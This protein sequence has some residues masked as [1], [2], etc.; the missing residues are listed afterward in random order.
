MDYLKQTPMPRE[1]TELRDFQ[2]NFYSRGSHILP[3]MVKVEPEERYASVDEVLSELG[4]IPCGTG[5]GASGS[6]I[7]ERINSYNSFLP[8]KPSSFPWSLL[9][10]VPLLG[11]GAVSFEYFCQYPKHSILAAN[12][13][14]NWSKLSICGSKFIDFPLDNLRFPGNETALLLGG[15][16]GG[17]C[18]LATE[19]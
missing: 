19:V 5:I 18:L 9:P 7:K 8:C 6:N 12:F 14:F 10:P 3:G 1:V 11:A 17:F 2:C 13:L 16:R 4:Y 15:V